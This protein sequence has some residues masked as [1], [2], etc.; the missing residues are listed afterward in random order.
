MKYVR[1]IVFVSALLSITG[2]SFAQT[3][4][5]G[6]SGNI[7][8]HG[9]G[10]IFVGLSYKTGALVANYYGQDV[11]S[12]DVVSDK[13][14]GFVLCFGGSMSRNRAKDFLSVLLT[15]KLHESGKWKVFGKTGLNADI[16]PGTKLKT[17]FTPIFGVGLRFN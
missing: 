15:P 10:N 1:F 14:Q 3:L 4:F 16:G 9:S 17:R 2:L 12:I 6:G 8:P 5:V 11:A 7:V 13:H